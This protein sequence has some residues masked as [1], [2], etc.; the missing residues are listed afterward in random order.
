MKKVTFNVNGI[1]S[2]LHQV[3]A[4]VDKY[5]PDLIALQETKCVDDAFPIKDI[6]EMGYHAEMFGQKG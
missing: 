6:S 3:K 5:S 1:R 2:R 4:V